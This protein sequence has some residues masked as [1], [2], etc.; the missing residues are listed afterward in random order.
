MRDP[1]EDS[2]KVEVVTT[3]PLRGCKR[4]LEI[5]THS[6]PRATIHR[7]LYVLPAELVDKALAAGG[8]LVKS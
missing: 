2:E 5:D 3:K 6:G 7:Y 1:A 4:Y 8:E